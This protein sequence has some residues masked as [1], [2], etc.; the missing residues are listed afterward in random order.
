MHFSFLALLS[1]GALTLSAANSVQHDSQVFAFEFR[2]LMPYSR[3]ALI[4]KFEP[5]HIDH[6][7]KRIALAKG[8]GGGGGG[9]GGGG[10]AKSGGGKGGK[11]GKDKKGH[12]Q[13]VPGTNGGGIEPAPPGLSAGGTKGMIH[14]PTI[15]NANTHR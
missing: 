11:K 3:Q 1:L 9:K 4:S 7:A 5:P 15:I 13:D 8:G 2:D 14:S 10:G 12:D 6:L